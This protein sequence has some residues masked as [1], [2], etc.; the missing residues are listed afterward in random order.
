MCEIE[1][2]LMS[3]TR[4]DIDEIIDTLQDLLENFSS[5]PQ[6]FLGIKHEGLI[7]LLQWAVL[8][9]IFVFIWQL[10]EAWKRYRKRARRNRIRTHSKTELIVKEKESQNT[11]EN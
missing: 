7:I 4:I 3:F 6:R 9:T 5:W 8:S 11:P 10:I 2:L 1:W